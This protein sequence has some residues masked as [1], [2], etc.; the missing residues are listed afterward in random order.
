MS[1]PAPN[2]PCPCRSG[3]KYKKCCRPWHQGSPAP[4]PEALMRSR[5]AAY[6]LGLVDYILDT[7]DP[8]GP[9]AR[10]DRRAWAADV[11]G[12]C[13]ATRFDGLVIL[14]S[15]QGSG[16]QGDE[17]WVRFRA[18]LVQDGSDA[19]FEERSRFVREGGRWRYH[20]GA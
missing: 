6:A 9:M 8:K 14:G 16:D 17:G 12:F 2:E 3:E 4:S 13:R 15:G 20:S 11:A 5:F 19:S 10:D 18:V 7:T 1:K